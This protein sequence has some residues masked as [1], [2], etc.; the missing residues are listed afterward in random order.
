MKNKSYIGISFIILIFGILFIPKIIDRLKNNNVIQNDRLNVNKQTTG[1]DSG[2]EVIG[3]APQFSLISQDGKT[4]TQGFYK[5]KVYVVEFFFSTCPSI[6]PVMNQNMLDIEKAFIGNKNF[7]IAS[8]TINPEYDTPAVLKDHAKQ[9]GVTSPNWNFLTGEK[10]YIYDLANK[11]F[12][13]FAGENKKV[14][15]G[16]EHSGLFAL[17]DKNGQV[18][19]RKDKNGNPIFYYTG[20]N[21]ND[22]EGIEED[23]AGKYRPGVV[24]IKED[25]KKLLEE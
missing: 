22:P 13:I 18:R 20:L 15:G 4:I 6:C 16:F 5:G 3:K 23:L 25:I 12:K 8:I 14:A 17:I 19:C 24:A 21:Y 1:R 7:G 9:L 2:L 11:G 10:Q